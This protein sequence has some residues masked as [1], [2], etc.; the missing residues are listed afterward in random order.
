M[1]DGLERIDKAEG[2]LGGAYVVLVGGVELLAAVAALEGFV[3]DVVVAHADGGL[4]VP[5]LAQ[6][7]LV[8]GRDAAAEEPAFV[9]VVLEPVPD[10]EGDV[11]AGDVELAAHQVRAEEPAVEGL[12][13]P[14]AVFGHEEPVA[15]ALRLGV[16]PGVPAVEELQGVLVGNGGF[17]PEVGSSG[18]PVQEVRLK[19]HVLRS[20]RRG[21][22]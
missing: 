14:V 20:R 11:D 8:S 17:D 15:S 19:R 13:K 5:V 7:P 9:A 22:A 12:A 16:F 1:G 18:S 21:D 2:C 4:E 10:A 6:H 3:L